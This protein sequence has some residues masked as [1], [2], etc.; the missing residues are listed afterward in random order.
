MSENPEDQ[1]DP[2]VF[3]AAREQV[4]RMK[5]E[6]ETLGGV[7]KRLGTAET[8]LASAVES[9]QTVSESV[10]SLVG[11]LDG[12]ATELEKLEPDTLRGE[13][14][15]IKKE[16]SESADSLAG[17]LGGELR[18]IKKEL[19]TQIIWLFV[20]SGGSLALLLYRMFVDW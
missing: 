10:G 13:L 5:S 9:M 8:S 12:V 11:R 18:D 2:E 1:V 3:L 15:D 20:I 7:S 4:E 17:R 6:L 19:G 16:I 14:R